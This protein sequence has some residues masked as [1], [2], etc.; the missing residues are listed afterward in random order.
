[1]HARGAEVSID[2]Q[3]ITITRSPLG[4]SLWQDES[5]AV[6]DLL[7]WN[8]QAPNGTSPGFIELLVGKEGFF[9]RHQVELLP[10]DEQAYAQIDR[11]L[12]NVQAG[13]PLEA[14]LEEFVGASDKSPPK[15]VTPKK[16]TPTYQRRRVDNRSRIW[17]GTVGVR[18]GRHRGGDQTSGDQT[19]GLRKVRWSEAPSGA[20]GSCSNP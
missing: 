15:A 2:P 14:G 7:G 12:L 18:H 3:R 8:K 5:I 17:A 4:T 1:M 6:T 11:A 10:A 16:E 9:R 19:T 20:V 13:Y